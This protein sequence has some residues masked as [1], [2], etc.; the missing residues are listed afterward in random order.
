[1]AAAKKTIAAIVTAEVIHSMARAKSCIE[2]ILRLVYWISCQ[3]SGVSSQ[4]SILCQSVCPMIRVTGENGD[5]AVNLFRHDEPR[6]P[7]RHGH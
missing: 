7:V 3:W 1:M 6:Q 4:F 5:G 2:G